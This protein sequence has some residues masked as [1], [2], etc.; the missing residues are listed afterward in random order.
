MGEILDIQ[1]LLLDRDLEA[2][3][4]EVDDDLEVMA[5]IDY[6]KLSQEDREAFKK[7]VGRLLHAKIVTHPCMKKIIE[8]EGG[9]KGESLTRKEIE[10]LVRGMLT[11]A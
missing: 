2:R 11:R 5:S 1:S 9:N 3:E 10:N 8:F 6:S 7:W 4:A